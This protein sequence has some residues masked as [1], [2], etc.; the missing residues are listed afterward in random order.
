MEEIVRELFRANDHHVTARGDDLGTLQEKQ[1]PEVLTV[2][3]GDSRVLQDGMWDDRPPGHIFTHSNIGNRVRQRTESGTVVAGDVLYPLV[4]TGTETVLVVGHTGCGAVTAAYQSLTDGFTDRPGIE[5]CVRLLEDD[6]AEAVDSLPGDIAEENA[7]NR[8]VEYN[9]D[10]Q[11]E[12]LC[13]SAD[14]PEAVTA[15]G[16]VYDFHDVYSDKRGGAHLVNVDGQRGESA[17]AA[18]YPELA[19]RIRRLWVY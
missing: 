7:V 18:Q 13:D 3:C 19:E 9:V 15:V 8:L 10:R 11:I 6:L 5:H 12:H 4:H 17:L 1:Q 2:S 16:V 14:V